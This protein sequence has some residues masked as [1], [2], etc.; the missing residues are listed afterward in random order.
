MKYFA[1]IEILHIWFIA[2]VEII[3]IYYFEFQYNVSQE[4]VLRGKDSQNV[5]DV[6]YEV[7][8]SAHHHL[9][10]VSIKVTFVIYILNNGQDTCLK[11]FLSYSKLVLLLRLL[12]CSISGQKYER[13]S[14]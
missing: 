6:I 14:P 4:D 10:L 2:I 5:K 11:E 3:I 8:S 13:E 7:A 9:E 12:N 1:R